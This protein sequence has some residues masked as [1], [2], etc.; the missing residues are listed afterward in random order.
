VHGDQMGEAIDHYDEVGRYAQVL[1][2]EKRR[3]TRKIS[4]RQPR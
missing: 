3:Q 4:V 1:L 2:Y